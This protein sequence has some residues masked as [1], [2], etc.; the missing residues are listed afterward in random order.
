[1]S[2]ELTEALFQKAAGW[3]VVKL[4]R[5][6]LAQGQVLSSDWAPPLLRGVVQSNGVSFRASMAIKAILILRISAPVARRGSGERFAPMASQLGC[7]G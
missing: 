2:V 3:D 5:A 6:Y 7:I 1:M 4:A